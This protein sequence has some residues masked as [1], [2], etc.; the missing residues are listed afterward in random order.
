MTN[1]VVEMQLEF[2]VDDGDYGQLDSLTHQLNYELQDL[3]IQ[4]VDY[5]RLEPISGV[6][7]TDPII[8]GALLI[9]VGPTVIGKVFE[10]LQAWTMR[11][12][13]LTMKIKIQTEHG[14]SLEIE[15]PTTTSPDEVKNWINTLSNT[16]A[17]SKSKK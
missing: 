12:E 8:V 9:A 16:L 2:N 10:F 7:S 3:D 15:V 14:E 13:G 6:K 4:S 1:N 17:K 5:L 11:R